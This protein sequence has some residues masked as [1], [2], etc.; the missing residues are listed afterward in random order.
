MRI[1]MSFLVPVGEPERDAAARA[2]REHFGDAA[3]VTEIV[4][5][6]FETK[7][8]PGSVEF[9]LDVEGISKDE[10]KEILE[11]SSRVPADAEHITCDVTVLTGETKHRAVTRWVEEE[12]GNET[13]AAI[14]IWPSVGVRL[15]WGVAYLKVKLVVVRKGTTKD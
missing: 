4:S 2:V 12:Y 11:A 7:P 6:D 13:S 1:T 14:A 8:R 5:S 3:S 9:E 15:D 10:V